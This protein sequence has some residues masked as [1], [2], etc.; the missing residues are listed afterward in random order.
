[1][2]HAL[3]KGISEDIAEKLYPVDK[4]KA[5]ERWFLEQAKTKSQIKKEVETRYAKLLRENCPSY[6]LSEREKEF[7]DILAKLPKEKQE[8]AVKYAEDG[9]ISKTDLYSIKQI[10]KLP[11]KVL[12]DLENSAHLYPV[13][14]KDKGGI[15]DYYDS[16]PNKYNPV[17]VIMG[18]P[19]C[20][21][22]KA[23]SNINGKIYELSFYHFTLKVD[24]PFVLCA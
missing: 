4:M 5:G 12:E 17:Y 22:P 6:N 18:F 3:E 1:M 8:L 13:I 19:N 24:Q 10:E 20:D 11:L 15:S 7:I 2:S 9:I 14:D 21:P 16:N 23:S